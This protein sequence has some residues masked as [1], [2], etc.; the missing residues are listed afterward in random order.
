MNGYG[1]RSGA[2]WIGIAAAGGTCAERQRVIAESNGDADADA[3]AAR[4]EAQ[5]TDDERLS[6]IHGFM[7]LPVAPILIRPK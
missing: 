2:P 5:M 4:V 3:W 1:S 7:P 6:L